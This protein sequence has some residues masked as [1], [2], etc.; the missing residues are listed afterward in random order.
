MN[1]QLTGQITD[2]TSSD[3]NDFA[4]MAEFIYE[5]CDDLAERLIAKA[6]QAAVEHEAYC[7]RLIRFCHTGK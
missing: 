2:Q 6:H 3:L 5:A 7:E 4:S 1:I